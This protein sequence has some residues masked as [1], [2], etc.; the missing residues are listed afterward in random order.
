MLVRLPQSKYKITFYHSF[1]Q[2][3]QNTVSDPG[4]THHLLKSALFSDTSER[5]HEDQLLHRTSSISNASK[6]ITF[7][8]NNN[9]KCPIKVTFQ[10]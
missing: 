1:L 2:A 10:R 5:H 4:D 6:A 9:K 8:R 7:L 3:I